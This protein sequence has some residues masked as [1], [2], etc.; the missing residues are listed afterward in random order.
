MASLLLIFLFLGFM[1]EVKCF[2]AAVNE[3][4]SLRNEN[5]LLTVLGRRFHFNDAEVEATKELIEDEDNN[6]DP[7]QDKILF[8]LQVEEIERKLKTMSNE[9]MGMIRQVFVRNMGPDRAEE[10]FGAAEEIYEREKKANEK[11]PKSFQLN[12]GEEEAFEDL[13][14][15]TKEGWDPE[16]E[17]LE[18]K[19]GL[20]ELK[21][22]YGQL[23][24][25]QE[26]RLRDL[27][28]VEFGSEEAAL[29]IK[30]IKAIHKEMLTLEAN[31]NGNN[32]T[33]LAAEIVNR[34]A[35]DQENRRNVDE[36]K[37]CGG[38]RS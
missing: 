23:S 8:R 20:S 16:M 33:R 15:D 9:E 26:E 25:E 18:F 19:L 13:V 37:K 28:E 5:R 32:G 11:L 30:E 31:T 29:I 17:D 34:V 36:N 4:I 6:I 3:S 14:E 21:D 27:V 2:P 7:E 10:V 38:D 35:D 12:R 24:P 1:F 22:S